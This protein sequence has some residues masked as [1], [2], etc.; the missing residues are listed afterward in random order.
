MNMFNKYPFLIAEISFN[1]HKIAQKED[2]S[3]FEVAKLMIKEAK[4]CGINAVNFHVGDSEFL[5]C[6]FEET[7]E[8]VRDKLSYDEY[9][10]LAEFCQEINILFFI[11]PSDFSDVDALDDFVDAYKIDHFPIREGD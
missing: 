6:N 2:C 11:T 8:E 4:K 7:I 1:F 9:K 3:Y 5:H 10:K